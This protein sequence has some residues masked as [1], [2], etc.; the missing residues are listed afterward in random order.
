MPSSHA[1]GPASPVAAGLL[2]AAICATAPLHAA[3]R[4]RPIVSTT[5][6]FLDYCFFKT[7]AKVGYFTEEQYDKVIG[8][9]AEAGFAKIYLRVDVCGVTLYPTK[10]GKQY[11]GD[12]RD[13][14]STY[15]VNTLRRYD[16]AAKTVELGH[17]HGLQVWAWDTIF[18]D[19]ATMVHYGPDEPELRERF[20][21]YPLKDPFLVRNPH[22]QWQLDPRIDAEQEKAANAPDRHAP[23]TA[24][25]IISDTASRGNR[26]SAEMFDLYVSADNSRYRK[27]T[28]PLRFE[29]TGTKPPA[30]LLDGLRIPEPYI[31]LAFHKPWPT[32]NSFTVSGEPDAF[33][34]LRYGPA[35]H[36]ALS[37]YRD[38]T[39]PPEKGGFDFVCTRFAWDYGTRALG[40]AKFVPALPR[41]YGIVEL[42]YPEARAH[43]LAKLREL[44]AY[45]FD[46]F[47]YSIRTHTLGRKPQH[48]GY[49]DATRNAF[50]QRYGKDIATDEFDREAWLDLRAEAVN[51]YL[52]E[53]GKLLQPRPLYMDFPRQE[54]GAPYI[55]RYGG[56]P[57]QADAW[58]RD[59]AV[60]GIRMLGFPAGE[61]IK[62]AF[63]GA[64]GVRIVRFV[65]NWRTPPPDEFRAN[66]RRWLDDPAL[67]EIEFYE[68]L[69]YTPRPEY[70]AIVREEVA[71]P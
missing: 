9:V 35:W 57:F 37:D 26:V 3:D 56:L 30:F 69:L 44:A 23:I 64:D 41:Y 66:L 8:A 48:Y 65:D 24:I 60:A 11:A 6:D 50:R 1:R 27:Y 7:D 31:K 54:P 4:G 34:Q 68:T 51:A 46:G 45:E 28:G 17:K 62:P 13:P 38:Q 40:I 53:A 5:I 70:L 20:G 12:G 71:R 16:P 10:A 42:A 63:A 29:V 67:D 55:G 2:T 49:N 33:V 36:V 59:Q 18:D 52:A 43:K 47:A 61:P 21:E 22:V 25:R 15:L 19:E 14:G 39:E 32:E 58:V